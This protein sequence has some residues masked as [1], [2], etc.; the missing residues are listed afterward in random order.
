MSGVESLDEAAHSFL[1]DFSVG[2]YDPARDDPA[3]T[4]DIFTFLDFIVDDELVWE[5]TYHGSNTYRA[6][7]LALYHD[8]SGYDASQKGIYLGNLGSITQ[9]EDLV[10]DLDNSLPM[11]DGITVTQYPASL[12]VSRKY[13]LPSKEEVKKD[14]MVLKSED[15][16]QFVYSLGQTISELKDGT[17]QIA[18]YKPVSN[19]GLQKGRL[20]IYLVIQDQVYNTNLYT[21]VQ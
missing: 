1:I 19:F 3:S 6:K 9:T 4:K 18:L 5:L 7:R 11:I 16:Q 13:T 8:G 21:V 12:T 2:K 20:D 10:F 14:Y 15:G 17:T